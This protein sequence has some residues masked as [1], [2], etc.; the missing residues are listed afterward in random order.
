MDKSEIVEEAPPEV[1]F[2]NPQNERTKQFL[3]QILNH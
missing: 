3:G 2:T 1:F